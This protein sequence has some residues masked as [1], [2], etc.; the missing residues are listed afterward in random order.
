M[1]TDSQW[2]DLLDSL[3]QQAAVCSQCNTYQT[4]AVSL[5]VARQRLSTADVPYPL[6]SRAIPA[7]STATLHLMLTH[8]PNSLTPQTLISRLHHTLLNDGNTLEF[9]TDGQSASSAWCR[10][11][12]WGPTPD[13]KFS[14]VWHV[15]ASSCRAP[16]LTRGRVCI[17]QCTPLTGQSRERP[18]TM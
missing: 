5:S 17:L 10:A 2:P 6:V 7:S 9:A 3:M 1:T 4:V 14:S 18:K 8:A 11:A 13:F 12:I 15:L 16:R